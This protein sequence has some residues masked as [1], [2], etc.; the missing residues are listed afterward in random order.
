MKSFRR[1][2]LAFS[3]ARRWGLIFLLCSGCQIKE[4]TSAKVYIQQN[5]WG[6]AVVQLEKAVAEHPENAEAQYLLG[7]GYA[8]QGKFAEMSRAFAAS[9]AASRQFELEIKTWRQQYFSEHFNAGVKAT[10]ENDFPAAREAFLTA[11]TIDSQPPEVY[12]SLAYVYA[13]LSELDKARELYQRALEIAPEDWEAGVAIAE[14]HRQRHDY[15]KSVAVLEQAL[16][17]HPRQPQILAALANVY[18]CLGRGDDALAAYQ[19]ALLMAPE[20]QDL[21]VSLARLHLLKKDYDEAMQ[22]YAKVLSLDP[23]HFEAN[24][25]VGLVYLDR[26]NFK[27]AVPFLLKA[28]QLDTLHAGAYFN[29]GVGYARLGEAEKAKEAFKRCEQLQ[30]KR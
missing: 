16:Q 13:K 19:Q 24:Y 12:K 5:N 9:L 20:N 21:M 14:L 15:E 23:D 30:E 26:K 8:R 28:A 17:K 6:K 3:I 11:K 18:D 22:Q 2:T 7:R 27:T 1:W 4:L 25:N 29:L 10:G